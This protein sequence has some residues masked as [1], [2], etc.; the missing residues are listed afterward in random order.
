LMGS[1]TESPNSTISWLVK[2]LL[3]FLSWSM[4]MLIISNLK[5]QK[6]YCNLHQ[7]SFQLKLVS[8]LRK[9]SSPELSLQF[10]LINPVLVSRLPGHITPTLK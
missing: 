2:K 3:N 4:V 6:S 10:N 8:S 1:F 7:S 9:E 5:H